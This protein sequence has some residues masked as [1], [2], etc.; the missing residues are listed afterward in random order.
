[1]SN[2]NIKPSHLA[3]LCPWSSVLG[4][5]EYEGIAQNIMKILK[6][7][8]DTFRLLSWEE[9]KLERIKDIKLDWENEGKANLDVDFDFYLSEEQ[10]YFEKVAPYC[11]S[12]DTAALF[13]EAWKEIVNSIGTE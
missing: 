10:A 8:G 3:L 13:C 2:A 4:K 1:M 6:R 11:K 12:G 5:S 7:N 9:Y